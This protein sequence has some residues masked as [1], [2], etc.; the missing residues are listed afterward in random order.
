MAPSS[1]AIIIAKDFG[2]PHVVLQCVR[3]ILCGH[4]FDLHN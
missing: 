3:S 1:A 4:Q 2:R